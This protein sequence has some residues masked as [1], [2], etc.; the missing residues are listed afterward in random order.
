M[1]R[2]SFSIAKKLSFSRSPYYQNATQ[3]QDRRFV[4]DIIGLT[5]GY[6]GDVIAALALI[7]AVGVQRK[8]QPEG[9]QT[10]LCL[11]GTQAAIALGYGLY[12]VAAIA[13]TIPFGNR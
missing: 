3:M 4:D 6:L 5:H 11:K 9:K 8:R 2:I 12:A 13:V 10:V 1:Q 7:C